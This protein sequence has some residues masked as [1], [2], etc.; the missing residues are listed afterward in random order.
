[1]RG[2]AFAVTVLLVFAL[3]AALSAPA[4]EGKV[5]GWKKNLVDG[6]KTNG[7]MKKLKQYRAQ[8]QQQEQGETLS[9]SMLSA[10]SVQATTGVN[11]RSGPCTSYSA[12]TTM[13]S[14]ARATYDG[15][16]PVSG[17]GYSWYKVNVGGRVGYVASNYLRQASASPSPSPSW[18]W[19]PSPAPAPTPSW[20]W[21]PSPA[22]R[23]APAPTPSWGS[24]SSSC[25]LKRFTHSRITGSSCMI[26]VQFESTMNR[27][28]S[29]AEQCRVKIHITSSWRPNANVAGAI[30]T[31]ATRSNHMAGHA[32]DFN[33]QSDSGAFCNSACLSAQNNP[34]FTCFTN[35]V[36]SD[37]SM[38]WGIS[39]NDPVHIDDGLN[40]KSTA[41]WDQRYRATQEANQRRCA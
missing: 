12:I 18:G 16:S 30:V 27:L 13:A 34:T 19:S 36:K 33:L 11:V 28:V 31:P 21:S 6:K 17:C 7:W 4:K 3:A 20:S 14:G 40:I 9:E 5:R 37:S 35:K 22:P 32:I 15:S 8:K 26:D 23:P 24:S 1:M 39:F 25:A 41:T 38:R 2:V 10:G 29:Y